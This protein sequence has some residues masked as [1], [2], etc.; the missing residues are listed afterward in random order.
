MEKDFR[1]EFDQLRPKIRKHWT[2]MFVLGIGLFPFLIL[3]MYF[4]STMP[5]NFGKYIP[6]GYILL[7]SCV[8]LRALKIKCPNCN[9]SL[10]VYKYIWKI[11]ILVQGM[12]TD[13]CQH[14]GAWL[15]GEE[16]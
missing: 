3:V 1:K 14:S 7:F 11:P 10:Y 15:K 9:K 16:K 13:H 8:S 5:N 2:I 6:L 12:I 4:F